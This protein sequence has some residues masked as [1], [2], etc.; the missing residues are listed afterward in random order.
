M[1]REELPP[2]PS[3]VSALLDA[4][5]AAFEAP[6]AD[7][8]TDLAQRLVSLAPS[9]PSRPPTPLVGHTAVG[10]AVALIVIGGIAGSAITVAVRPAPKPSEARVVTVEPAGDTHAP[11][12]T[13]ASTEAPG[14]SEAPPPEPAPAPPPPTPSAATTSDR[15]LAR[16]RSL[17]EAARSAVVRRDG[18]AALTATSDHQRQFPSGRLAEE[19]EALAV[20]GLMLVGRAD[21]AHAR[22]EQ[23]R[24][25]YPNGL[26][27]PVVEAAVAH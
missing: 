7:V 1:K 14:P 20:Q 24:R 10:K 9:F 11:V 13:A 8:R 22:A 15:S 5:R 3:A 18:A 21:E 16:E 25:R 19:R 26:F 4:E 6:P 27:L 2:L 17:I 23:F 12:P